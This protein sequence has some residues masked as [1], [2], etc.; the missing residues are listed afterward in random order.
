MPNKGIYTRSFLISLSLIVFEP[1]LS[2]CFEQETPNASHFSKWNL[3]DGVI[4]S[5]VHVTNP[6]G[7]ITPYGTSY[8]GNH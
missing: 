1:S 7:N 4:G 5:M 8:D 3:V 2:H 6:Y